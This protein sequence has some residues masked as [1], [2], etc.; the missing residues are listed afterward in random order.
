MIEHNVINIMP[1]SSMRPIDWYGRMYLIRRVEQTLLRLFSEGALNGTTHTSIGQ[2]ACAVGVIQALDSSRDVVF[3]NHRSHGHYLAL[4]DDVD[5]LIAELMGRA[6]GPCGGL[7]GSQH[8]AS[9]NFY[10]NGVLG[11]TLAPAVGAAF[12]LRRAGTGGVSVPFLGDGTLGE[13]VVYEAFN[14]AALWR[15]PVLFVVEHNHIAQS[16]PSNLE[17]AGDIRLRAVP[18]GIDVTALEAGDPEKV[19]TAALERIANIRAGQGPHLLFLDT[20]RLGPH[21]KGDDSRPPEELKPL[22]DRDPLALL[23]ARIGETPDRRAVELA[24]DARV[25]VALARAR[26]APELTLRDLLELSGPSI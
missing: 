21:S 12:A 9:T 6:T 7:G 25:A 24:V 15:L 5:G 22:W 19:C 13:G 18:F 10:S 3:S 1:A 14:L 20:Y 4:T 17:H 11:S 16:T 23:A 8:L 26:G 2:E